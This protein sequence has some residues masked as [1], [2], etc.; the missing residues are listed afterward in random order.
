MPARSTKNVLLYCIFFAGGFDLL[1]LFQR[2]FVTIVFYHRF[3]ER[4]EPF[5]LRAD[6]FEK[7]IRFFKKKYHLISLCQYI[8]AMNGER[9]LP[10]NP[11]IVTIDDG[12]RDN[13]EIAYR[14]LHKHAVPATIFLATDFIDKRAWLWP[15]KLEFILRNS[16]F[17]HFRF[18]LNGRTP[19]FRID[20]F[21]SWHV[22]QLSIFNELR[23][24][25]DKKKNALL[26]GL[27]RELRVSVPEETQ[28]D[29]M[30]LTWN[31]IRSMHD[32]GIEF[33][34]H[35]CTHPILSRLDSREIYREVFDSKEKI[36]DALQAR[37]KSFCYPNGQF[38]DYSTEVVQAL[39]KAKYETALT[40]VPGL[41][42]FNPAD[43]YG[44]R[45]FSVSGTDFARISKQLQWQR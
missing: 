7:Q 40:T 14:L 23:Q 38:E 31:Q 41:N 44:L 30:P 15:N 6:R 28:E 18:A 13:F 4:E 19:E 2:R 26:E 25:A 32:G 34:S 21:A 33:G 3:S 24:M 27:A 12:Y 11:L 20:S 37:V 45:R 1:R 17:D 35:S 9:R 5:K 10:R 43:R 39:K 42:D 8:Q 22:T 36:E 16:K 29:F